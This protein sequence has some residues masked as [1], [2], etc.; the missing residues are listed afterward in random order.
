MSKQ[1][2]YVPPPERFH[3]R[4]PVT[5]EVTRQFEAR[6][7]SGMRAMLQMLPDG[8]ELLAGPTPQAL[9]QQ[10]VRLVLRVPIRGHGSG[11]P[12]WSMV[13]FADQRHDFLDDAQ[14]ALEGLRVMWADCSESEQHHS[15]V[16][17]AIH[18]TYRALSDRVDEEPD[19]R[20]IRTCTKCGCT[21]DR[22]CHPPCWWV[23]DDLC[24]SCE[25]PR[26]SSIAD[27][28][29]DLIGSSVTRLSVTKLT[30]DCQ[31]TLAVTR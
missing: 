9:G 21:Q 13:G 10:E 17:S 26:A 28:W 15:P 11:H 5:R 25:S 7:G 1:T 20:E 27:G 8:I 19:H 24:S 30:A 29:D 16:A 31:S 2:R 4:R 6:L 14:T 12:A 3:G 22:A 18:K 23:A